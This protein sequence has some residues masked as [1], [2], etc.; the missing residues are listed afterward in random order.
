MTTESGRC[1]VAA[2]RQEMAPE[3]HPQ[4]PREAK[5]VVPCPMLP[6]ACRF[7]AAAVAGAAAEYSLMP[8]LHASRSRH[9]GTP[10]AS[11]R[12]FFSSKKL[13]YR[14]ANFEPICMVLQDEPRSSSE[15]EIL[16]SRI[17]PVA[18]ESRKR[19]VAHEV[20]MVGVDVR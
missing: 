18:K 17:A 1:M 5:A 10:Y 15:M 19:F 13:S 14:T 6:A 7:A 20:R 4:I 12:S 16:T 11:M 3:R 2:S 8:V 9:C